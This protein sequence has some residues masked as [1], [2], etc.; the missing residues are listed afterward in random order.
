MLTKPHAGW[1]EVIIGEFT[2]SASYLDDVPVLT[3]SAMISHFKTGN[4][5]CVEYDAEGSEFIVVSNR[6]ETLVIE[7]EKISMFFI[8]AEVL[9]RELIHD[10]ED[11]L[12]LWS[13][14]NPIVCERIKPKE[15][16]SAKIKITELVSQLKEELEKYGE[17]NETS[18]E[19]DMYDISLCKE[20]MAKAIKNYRKNPWDVFGFKPDWWSWLKW[21]LFYAIWRRER[22]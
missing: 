14:W 12:D 2:G 3:L 10:I 19:N 11:N 15:A 18:C 20:K 6:Y 5:F 17:C 13:T 4:P 8:S 7:D 1:T 22:G 9:A 21:R 16:K